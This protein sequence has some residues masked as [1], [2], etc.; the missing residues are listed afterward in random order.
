MRLNGPFSGVGVDFGRARNRRIDKLDHGPEFDLITRVWPEADR[1]KRRILGF[2]ENQPLRA[3][4]RLCNGVLQ[5]NPENR[6]CSPSHGQ[7]GHSALVLDGYTGC[8]NIHG[9]NQ[10]K[11][12][13]VRCFRNTPGWG[14]VAIVSCRPSEADV[15]LRLD[16]YDCP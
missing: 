12:A 2:H 6:L 13:E 7:A 8:T 15:F 16:Q 1:Q 14:P 3:V 9:F 11:V 10:V 4:L 5:I